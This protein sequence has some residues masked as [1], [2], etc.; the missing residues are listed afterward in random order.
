MPR[1]ICPQVRGIYHNNE[2]PAKYPYPYLII[3]NDN[4]NSEYWAIDAYECNKAGEI[5]PAKQCP[6]PHV[7]TDF[8][9]YVHGIA[10]FLI[11]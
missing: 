2:A 4:P 5:N 8:G 11:S 7:A 3:K 1:T 6:E 10:I 9:D